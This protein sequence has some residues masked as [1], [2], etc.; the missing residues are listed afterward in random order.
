MTSLEGTWRNRTWRVRVSKFIHSYRCMNACQDLWN[1]KPKSCA[2]VEQGGW[3]WDCQEE[4]DDW[5]S[6]K[7][8]KMRKIEIIKCEGSQKRWGEET[9]SRQAVVLLLLGEF[10]RVAEDLERRLFRTVSTCLGMLTAETEHR[11]VKP[12][13]YRTHTLMDTAEAGSAG[14]QLRRV[15]EQ[16]L[17]TIILKL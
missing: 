12:R 17:S 4:V 14:R 1:W 15:M 8:K 11:P 7:K 9:K 6:K 2:Q 5:T 3:F 13:A 10:Q 16:T